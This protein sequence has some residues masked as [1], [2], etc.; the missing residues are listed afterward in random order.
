M[1]F[2]HLA[3]AILAISVGAS[4]QT[5]PASVSGNISD[6]EGRPVAG[7][8]VRISGIGARGTI[9]KRADD[10][11]SYRAELPAAGRY[12]LSVSTEDGR[13]AAAEVFEIAEGES[14]NL[15]LVLQRL[16]ALRE[17]VDVAVSAGAVQPISDVSK[18]V[19][20]IGSEEL[21]ARGDISVVD[22]LKTI[23]GFRVQQ[24]GG[25]GSLANIKTRG[26][27]EQATSV[28]VDGIRFRD[29]TAITGD[30]SPFLAD[31]TV[32]G[33]DRIEVLRGS[34]SSV[35]GTNAIG[36]VVDLRT[37]EP[38]RGI[39]GNFS[40]DAGGLGLK[41]LVA[42]L[43]GGSEE[44]SAG[45]SFSRTVFS[46]GI[47]GEDDALNNGFLGRA[48]YRPFGNTSVGGKLFVSRADLRLNANP[49]TLGDVSGGSVIDARPGINF[50]P[51]DNDPDSSQENRLIGYQLRLD[52][53]ITP[54]LLFTASFQGLES[55]RTTVNGPLGPG[56][57][58][59]GGEESGTFDG[60]IDTFQAR[61]DWAAAPSQ[62]LTV[63][64][65][66]ESETYGNS[67]FG[68]FPGSAFS[69]ESGQR[70]NTVFVQHL[71]GF[72]GSR[73]QLAGGF[74]A[75]AFSIGNTVFSAGNAPYEDLS[76]VDP[77]VSYTFDGAGSWYFRS[78]GTKLRAHV[79][80]GYR[81]PSLYE[82]LGT[83]W[84]SFSQEF[85]ALGDPDLKPERSISFDAG[86]EQEL[87]KGRARLSASYFYSKMTDII[88]FGSPAPDIGT[89]PRPFG[90]YRNEDGGI[91]RGAELSASLRPLNSSYLFV[92]YTFTNSDQLM[93]EVAGSGIISTLG[94]PVHQF[95]LVAAQRLTDRLTLSFDL[96]A[97]GDYLAPIFSNTSFTTVIYRFD[98]NRR[99]DVSAMYE[100]PVFSERARL[101]F[102]GTLQ[103]VFDY[104]YFENGFRTEGRTGRVGVGIE[105]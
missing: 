55:E 19:N 23:P 89:T 85:V 66:F 5:G 94:I 11:G 97:T 84:S 20:V 36:G 8:Q 99:G 21:S 2:L 98:G 96:T 46:K 102:R 100:I 52:Q 65:E 67:G 80:N 39:H 24:F 53:I 41:R 86:I 104:G 7:A 28:L 83:F 38:G 3:A 59:F 63:G 29:P 103:N 26:L 57:Q 95:T 37:E 68:P 32:L 70:S 14:V 76:I 75:Q 77:P 25:F 43:S 60:G 45:G 73:L 30:A 105:F 40:T 101:R 64:Y 50:I 82:R 90:G 88:G 47:D 33:I 4:G 87:A 16:P 9:E 6:A 15:S 1:K 79:G 42:G 91:A 48:D 58:P 31:L 54:S 93:P 17:V 61:I 34:G 74:R 27:Q 35:Y 18:T 44:F 81:V 49:D 56:F 78:S 72:F 22:A 10:A 62:N 13:R 12:I 92:S 69:A 71:A 51:D